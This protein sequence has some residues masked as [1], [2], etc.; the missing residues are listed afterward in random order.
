ME[1]FAR[2][3]DLEALNGFVA[4]VADGPCAFVL[5][6][7]PGIGKTTLWDA[8]VDAA[9]ARSYR[10]LV[11]PPRRRRGAAVVRGARRSARGRSAGDARGV[12]RA[13]AAR[14]RGR[15][16]ARGLARPPA[17]PAR[18]RPR[19]TRRA[20][21]ARRIRRR[22]SS[23]IDDAQ[24]LDAPTAAV[25]EFALRRLRREP[26]G[27][28]VAG[29][30][31]GGLELE[32]AL[33][34]ERLRVGPL[35]E[36]AIHRVV[37]AQLDVALPRPELLR[38]HE[39]SGGNPFYALELARALGGAGGA[40]EALRSRVA[41]LSDDVRALLLVV[42]LLSDPTVARLRAVVPDA[43][44]RLEAAIDAELLE[45]HGDRIRFTHAL[46]AS[47]VSEHEGA[48]RRRDV[49]RRLA[50]VER[51]F[52]GAC[53]ASR[54]C[55]GR[56]RRRGRR[57]A[58]PGRARR[59]RARCAERGGGAARARDRAH[60]AGAGG[61]PHARKARARRR[62]LQLGRDRPRQR[63]PARAARRACRP[64]TSAPT[65]SS[66]SR[67]AA[68]TSRR[69]SSSPSKRCSRSTTTTSSA[70]GCTCCSARRGRCAGW[71]PRSRTA[72]SRSITPSA[73]G[74]GVSS[75]TSSRG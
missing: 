67:T 50:E 12:A 11:E 40:Q 41:S 73:Q 17:R 7:E 57:G 19:A 51:R 58:R 32:R 30:T 23:A 24:W 27:V 72:A 8:A 31:D 29:R 46:L 70:A 34:V 16:P 33:P 69:R 68:P 6:G 61:R 9:H 48:E 22:C 59:A 71:S 38:I 15:T 75:S 60:A 5:E 18:D 20:A 44:A 63:G 62:A 55:D 42:S 65:S 45:R 66:G 2:E 25:L 47:A 10:V 39:A 36:A 49:H 37:R 54:A 52:G 26:V 43:D 28:L 64:A 35:G 14:A 1:V 4:R 3:D 21:R 56:P 53:P 74:T 13:E